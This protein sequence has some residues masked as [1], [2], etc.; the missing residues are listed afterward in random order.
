MAER[1]KQKPQ[2]PYKMFHYEARVFAKCSPI[3]VLWPL[4][5]YHHT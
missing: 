1:L 2:Q 5:Q 3:W 4:A